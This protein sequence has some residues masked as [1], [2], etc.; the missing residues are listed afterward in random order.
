MNKAKATFDALSK[1]TGGKPIYADAASAGL[2]RVAMLSGDTASIKATYAP[3]LANPDAFS[4]STLMQAAVTAAR[5]DQDAD[6]TK[7][8]EAALKQNPYHRDAL[9][10][11]ARMFIKTDSGTKALPVLR[12]LLDVDPANADN[13]KLV[14]YA[15]SGIRK[16]YANQDRALSASE[17]AVSDSAARYTGRSQT[18]LKGFA[19]RDKALQVREAAYA[20]SARVVTDSAIKYNSLGDSLQVKVV[21]SE[22]TPTDTKA[23][24]GR[25]DL[26]SRKRPQDVRAEDQLSGQDGRGCYH[27][28]R[29]RRPR[30]AEFRYHLYGDRNGTGNRGVQVLNAAVDRHAEVMD[31]R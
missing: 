12:R 19:D 28:G 26:Q 22:F 24:L 20:D 15:Y 5:A 1:D 6:A 8:F 11:V 9:F 14:A 2:A 18:V 4:Y 23:T 27:A 17:K 13:Y 16:V 30:Q 21:F 7:L 29:D 31:L 10:N 25:P 3:Q